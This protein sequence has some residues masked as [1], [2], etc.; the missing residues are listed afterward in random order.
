M[1]RLHF[2][3]EVGEL[4]PDAGFARTHVAP[5]CEWTCVRNNSGGFGHKG[6]GSLGLVYSIQKE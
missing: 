5:V 4:G 3:L 2:P 6:C 1:V